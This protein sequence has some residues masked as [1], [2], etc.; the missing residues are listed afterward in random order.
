[1]SVSVILA[2]IGASAATPA[3]APVA[4]APASASSA[5]TPV[6]EKKVCVSENVMGSIM[7]KRVC[8][9]QAEWEAA[10]K[11]DARRSIEL[12]SRN[13]IRN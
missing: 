1:M 10:R 3:V 6:K 2:F 4:S 11:E 7:P 12:P 8:R 5:A 13:P 9:T